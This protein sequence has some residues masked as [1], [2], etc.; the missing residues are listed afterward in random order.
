M[1]IHHTHFLALQTHIDAFHA[2]LLSERILEGEVSWG[3]WNYATVYCTFFLPPSWDW[4][5]VPFTNKSV[6][7]SA[8]PECMQ[9]TISKQ[10]PNPRQGWNCVVCFHSHHHR[11]ASQ[12][13]QYAAHPS[14]EGA[15]LFQGWPRTSPLWSFKPPPSLNRPPQGFSLGG[16][17]WQQSPR[18]IGHTHFRLHTPPQ[19]PLL[20]KPCSCHVWFLEVCVLHHPTLSSPRVQWQKSVVI[21]SNFVHSCLWFYT[22]LVRCTFSC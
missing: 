22:E 12:G 10:I 16:G 5:C 17:K 20:G 8:S 19:K 11:A 2:Y 4:L 1:Y 3:N 6:A 9:F 7:S 21:P 15:A 13:S 14:A 18:Q